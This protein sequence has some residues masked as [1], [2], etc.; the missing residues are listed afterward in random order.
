MRGLGTIINTAAIIAGGLLGLL[1]G[2]MITERFRDTLARACGI[3]VLFIGISGALEGMLTVSA[4]GTISSG[5][6]LLI[7]GCLVL[8]SLLGELCNIEG[9]FEK[10]GEWLKRKT[11]S[12]GDGSFVDGFVSASFT[13]CIGAM[14]IVGSIE[15]G[16][17]GDFSILLTKSILDFIIIMVMTGSL[18]KGCIFSALPVAVLQGTVTA[19]SVFIKPIITPALSN[20]SLIG[21][22]LIFCVGI[23]LVWGKRIKVANMLPAILFA[24]GAAFLPFAL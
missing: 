5:R 4:D 7:I 14:A 8:G 19:L 15:D 22:I 9:G 17:S 13:V 1:F 24:V 23:N 20:L 11:K 6:A 12:T 21:S 2:K 10:L 18:G 16:I 3:S